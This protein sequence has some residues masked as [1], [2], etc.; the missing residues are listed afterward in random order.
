MAEQV[1]FSDKNT[2]LKMCRREEWIYLN[3]KM[4]NVE[5]MVLYALFFLAFKSLIIIN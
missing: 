4:G 5:I 3:Y 2:K 1:P